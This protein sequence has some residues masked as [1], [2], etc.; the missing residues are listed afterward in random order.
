MLPE[1]IAKQISPS[2]LKKVNICNG[3]YCG[4]ICSLNLNNLKR[5]INKMN[6]QI[7]DMLL[8]RSKEIRIYALIIKFSPHRRTFL[9]DIFTLLDYFNDHINVSIHTEYCD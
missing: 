6:F 8:H 5:S 1:N 7:E 2:Y 3:H 4:T 9:C